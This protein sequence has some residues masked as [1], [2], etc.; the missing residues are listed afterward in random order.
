MGNKY[1]SFLDLDIVKEDAP[2]SLQ[3]R[4][5][6]NVLLDLNYLDCFHVE[7][8]KGYHVYMLS[9]ELLPNEILYHLEKAYFLAKNGRPGPVWIDIPLDVQGTMVDEKNLKKFKIINKIYCYLFIPC[10]SFND[11]FS[12]IK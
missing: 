2:L 9:D 12:H 10:Q 3:Q 4:L 5:K 8:K 11:H 7:T 1:L 6:K